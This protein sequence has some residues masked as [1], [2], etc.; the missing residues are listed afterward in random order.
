MI[1]FHN[2]VLPNI[3]DGSKSLEMSIDMLKHAYEQGITDVVNT[4][5][6]QHPKMEGKNINFSIIKKEIKLLQEELIQRDINIKLHCG[7]EVFFLPNLMR[8]KDDPL[9]TFIHG[10]YMLI[11]FQFHQISKIQK[12]QLFDLKM[13][14]VTPIIA[15]P[16]RYK[17][18]QEDLSLVTNWLERGCII[19]ID[20]GSI[21]GTLGS[22]A[23]TASEK[24]IKNGWCHV[25]GSDSHDNKSRNFCL[26]GAKEIVDG[27]VGNESIKMVEDNPKSIIEGKSIIYDFE[28]DKDLSSSNYFLPLKKFFG[29]K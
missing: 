19:Q 14:G 8:I 9:S 23:K 27:W 7:S 17:A 10:K 3:D 1:D 24:I 4:V 6:Y 22:K 11:E 28:Y 13:S 18:V 12:Q 16:E 25:L 15:H 29:V 26:K 21:L 2:H 5:H 20:A